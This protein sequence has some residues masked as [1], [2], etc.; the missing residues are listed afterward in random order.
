MNPI[1]KKDLESLAALMEDR[2]DVVLAYLFG[3][4]A[5]SEKVQSQ[6]SDIDIAVFFSPS[7]SLRE[8]LSFRSDLTRLLKGDR[9]D[10]VSLNEASSLLKYE[11]IL[12]GRAIYCRDSL[13]QARFE[14][15]TISHFLDTQYLRSVQNRYLLGEGR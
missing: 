9:V 8:L 6:S 11:V 12:G 1:A 3:S 7:P 14:M 10:L 4:Q 2:R 15:K 5:V 13:F